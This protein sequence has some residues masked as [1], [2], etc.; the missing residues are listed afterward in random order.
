M[1]WSAALIIIAACVMAHT[2]LTTM[3]N[4]AAFNAQASHI[5]GSW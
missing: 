3:E 2:V 4:L 5:G 1:N